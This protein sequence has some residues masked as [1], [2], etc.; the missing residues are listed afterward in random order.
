MAKK[1][2]KG[3]NAQRKA[4]QQRAKVSN[5]FGRGIIAAAVIAGIAFVYSAVL[6]VVG[7]KITPYISI[8]GHEIRGGENLD[9]SAIED[10]LELDENAHLFN[11]STREI[12]KQIAKIEG[13]EKVRVNRRPFEQ[14][15]EIRITQRTP[16]YLFVINNELLW[17]DRYGYLW[18]S[19]NI[20]T[21]GNIPLIV[22]LR[23]FQSEFGRRIVPEDLKRL[24]RTYLSVRGTGRNANNIRSM[25]FRDFGIVEFTASNI[26]VPVRLNGTLRF[27]LDDFVVFEDILRRNRRAPVRYLDAFENVVY[28]R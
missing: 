4:A 12:S 23:V 28:A 11:V 20:E 1:R 14:S 17:A 13:V 24:E 7:E 21:R 8:H 26:S 18:A 15:L 22:G 16:R 19:E 10:I 3:P 9:L 2:R 27:G 5:F 6:P 25:H